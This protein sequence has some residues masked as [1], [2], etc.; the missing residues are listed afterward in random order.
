MDARIEILNICKLIDE[1]ISTF[2]NTTNTLI[3][4]RYESVVESKLILNLCIRHLE[5]I[6][7]LAKKDLVFLPSAMTLSRSVFES[8]VN[9]LWM[10]FP[11]DI[12]ECETRYISHLKEYEDWLVGQIKFFNSLKWNAD[13]YVN[14]KD[15]ISEFRKAIEKLLN[16]KGYKI[17]PKQ[18]IRE[19]LKSI[20]EERKYLYYKLLS[21]YTHGGYYSTF[22]YRKNLG[23]CMSFGE[24][25]NINDWKF[26]YC[27]SWPAFEIA[28][29]LFIEKASEGN[30][31]TVYS[32]KFKK[33][34]RTALEM[35]EKSN[36]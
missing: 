8:A 32:D 30:I 14:E 20:N 19:I 29:E 15:I 18:K 28:S 1:G 31:N 25:I 12:Y 21:G 2:I 23:T 26:L 24:F 6:N 4:G 3:I 34:I 36:S 5:S 13:K 27:I 35:A 9:V 10:M 7:E 22:L 16:E 33:E 11:K 17:Y